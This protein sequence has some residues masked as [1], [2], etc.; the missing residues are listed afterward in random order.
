MIFLWERKLN[1]RNPGMHVVPSDPFLKRKA[2]TEKKLAWSGNSNLGGPTNT[3]F[4]LEKR[5]A[6]PE[7]KKFFS[8]LKER[9]HGLRERKRGFFRMLLSKKGVGKAL[10]KE[11]SSL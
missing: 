3:L 4:F 5:K 10:P 7:K 2:S 8:F 11:A 6:R 9:E 1:Q